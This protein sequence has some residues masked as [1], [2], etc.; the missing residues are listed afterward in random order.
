MSA[1]KVEVTEA[2]EGNR[3]TVKQIMAKFGVVKT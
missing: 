3:L 2:V 1:T